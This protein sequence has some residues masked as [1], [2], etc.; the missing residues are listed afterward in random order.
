MS[1]AV[2]ITTQNQKTA[3]LLCLGGDK[4]SFT[5]KATLHSPRA[6]RSTSPVS[7][8]NTAASQLTEEAA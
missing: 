4:S 8:N 6:L 5:P 2:P 7:M 1:E 3:L